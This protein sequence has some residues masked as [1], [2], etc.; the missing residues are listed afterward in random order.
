MK[1]LKEINMGKKREN[2]FYWVIYIKDSPWQVARYWKGVG[3]RIFGLE[4]YLRDNELSEIDERRITR[5]DPP[6]RIPYGKRKF[7]NDQNI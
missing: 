4:E 2:G 3:F 7:D 6:V 1:T 5:D